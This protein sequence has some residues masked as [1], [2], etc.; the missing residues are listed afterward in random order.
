MRRLFLAAALFAAIVP[1]AFASSDQ[2]RVGVGNTI[3]VAEDETANDIACVF[4][5]VHVQ[6]KVR[7]DVAV[8]FGQ[9]VVD[10][11]QSIAGDVAGLGADLRLE[12]GA[13]VGGDVAILAG[14]AR[15]APGATI[16]G[17]RMVMPGRFWLLL[18]LAPL[19]ILIGIIWL[20]VHIVRRN[21][22]Q[23]PAYPDGRGY[24]AGVYPPR[25]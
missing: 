15:V 20:I 25:R 18:P 24:Q 4:C 12:E 11:G 1:P 2:D 19:L 8:L 10:E 9:I 5:T 16:H 3:T 17:D 6:G 13:T 14:D 7:G 23:Y 22:Y 21:R